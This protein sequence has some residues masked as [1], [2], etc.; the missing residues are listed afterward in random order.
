[1]TV[2]YS[3]STKRVIAPLN[4]GTI[5]TFQL[6]EQWEATDIVH[7]APV[8]LDTMAESFTN[9]EI[10]DWMECEISEHWR[11]LAYEN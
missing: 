3:P 6:N 1:M 9:E 11:E 4:M 2:L 7:A 10:A 5:A 8:D